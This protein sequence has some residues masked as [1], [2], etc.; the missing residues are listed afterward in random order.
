MLDR[1][2]AKNSP[3]EN[4]E[5]LWSIAAPQVGRVL[6]GQGIARDDREDLAQDTALRLWRNFDPKRSPDDFI[7]DS[8]HSAR[9]AARVFLLQES[10]KE[11][12]P[13]QFFERRPVPI[14]DIWGRQVPADKWNLAEE[15]SLAPLEWRDRL[16]SIKEDPLLYYL[17]IGASPREAAQLGGIPRHVLKRALNE[18]RGRY[19]RTQTDF[20]RIRPDLLRPLPEHEL[21]PLPYFQGLFPQPS[22]PTRLRRLRGYKSEWI[23][24][25]VEL[26]KHT[27]AEP[28][29][30]GLIR[31][32]VGYRSNLTQ[33]GGLTFLLA[34][35]G[36]NVELLEQRFL[37]TRP[38]AQN[39]IISFGEIHQL[40]RNENSSSVEGPPANQ[41]WKDSIVTFW[42]RTSKWEELEPW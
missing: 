25:F 17:S 23:A 38:G 3:P 12:Q 42:V 11:S 39:Q 18:D 2:N 15:C 5:A 37:D 32:L 30:F 28:I 41:G 4:F 9:M 33:E 24:W 10:R 21:L 22:V 14:A 31:R 36:C 6:A 7:M 13:P 1:Q 35:T 40:L 8:R 27:S 34:A 29:T 20:S 26:S 16:Q 19:G